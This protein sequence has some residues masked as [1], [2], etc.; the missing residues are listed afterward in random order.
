MKDF[1]EVARSGNAKMRVTDWNDGMLK[2][3]SNFYI[4]GR[5]RTKNDK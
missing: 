5:G 1:I 2:N 3:C 4:I